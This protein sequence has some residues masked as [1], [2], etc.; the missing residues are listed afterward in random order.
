PARVGATITPEILGPTD[1]AMGSGPHG[2]RCIESGR[3][4]L[5]CAMED[6]I[7]YQSPDARHVAE[8]ATVVLHG[9][10]PRY[11][12]R[13]EDGSLDC[14][15]QDANAPR[16]TQLIGGIGFSCPLYS[17]DCIQGASG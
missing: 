11:C 12:H 1:T 13:F 16:A 9:T 4:D 15:S 3:D 8:I 2:W 6:Q 17:D 5:W 14:W 7:R 10:W